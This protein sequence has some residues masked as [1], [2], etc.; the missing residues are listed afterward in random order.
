MRRGRSRC[1]DEFG[2]AV[3]SRNHRYACSSVFSPC[4]RTR[5]RRV[6]NVSDER[7]NGTKRPHV[8]RATK[9]KIA[10]SNVSIRRR[11]CP[12]L[13]VHPC[14]VSY[15]MTADTIHVSWYEWRNNGAVLGKREFQ[16]VGIAARDGRKQHA[17]FGVILV[18][19]VSYCNA[20]LL[21][22]RKMK[23]CRFKRS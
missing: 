7:T 5:R 10:F 18:L 13:R 22:V 4:V 3:N 1:D 6:R 2:G 8:S 14:A 20:G 23:R 21:S 9:R 19:D 15:E 17:L 12:R 16:C 11:A